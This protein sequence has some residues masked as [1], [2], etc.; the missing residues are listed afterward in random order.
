MR[1]YD[2]TLHPYM[3]VVVRND[4][5]DAQ[6]AVQGT[7]AA[8]EATRAFLKDGDEH[9]SVIYLIVKSEH[10]LRQVVERARAAGISFKTFKEPDFG[11]ELTAMATAPLIGDERSFFK[12]F[13]LMK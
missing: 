5:S 8:I 3:Y 10:K 1:N 2:E 11:D 9:P 6:K 4:L 7:H 13:Q 12:R